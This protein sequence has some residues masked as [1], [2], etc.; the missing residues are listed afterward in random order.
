MERNDRYLTDELLRDAAAAALDEAFGGDELPDAAGIDALLDLLEAN[1]DTAL[2]AD[3]TLERQKQQTLR[4]LRRK[5]RLSP[6]RILAAAA[7]FAILTAAVVLGVLQQSGKIDVL[8]FGGPTDAQQNEILDVDALL[9]SLH[10]H[11][12]EQVAL[13]QV[14]LEDGW[15]AT[16]PTYYREGAKSCVDFRVYNADCCYCFSLKKGEE[17]TEDYA[18]L[19]AERVVTIEKSVVIYVFG[20]GAD[21]SEMRYQMNDLTYNVTAN[22]PTQTMI[23]TANQIENT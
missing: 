23:D 20:S 6:R 1:E 12:F 7:A 19:G 11:A 10:D 5:R 9:E 16:T 15:V 18:S 21:L 14:F 2:P 22:V 17:N 13:S 8:P 4:A 3:E